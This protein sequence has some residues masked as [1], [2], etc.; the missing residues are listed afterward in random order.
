MP[1]GASRFAQFR[2]GCKR[3]GGY[4][5]HL[6][7]LLEPLNLSIQAALPLQSLNQARRLGGTHPRE[8]IFHR[9]AAFPHRSAQFYKACAI[10]TLGG[11]P[12]LTEQ[13][14]R[15]ADLL[16]GCETHSW[17]PFC[18]LRRRIRLLGCSHR[19]R[20]GFVSDGGVG[21]CPARSGC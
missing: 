8:P 19:G 7:R 16:L 2:L 6:F 15:I 11:I 12:C 10:H 21:A 13:P 20:Y 1:V 14:P 18:D 5:I 3:G 17:V 9:P 4:G